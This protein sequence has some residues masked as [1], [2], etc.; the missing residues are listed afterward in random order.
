MKMHKEEYEKLLKRF[1]LELSEVGVTEDM[2]KIVKA[3]LDRSPNAVSS[4]TNE[5]TDQF[6]YRHGGYMIEA[7]QTVNL[8]VKKC[9]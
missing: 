1:A 2:L 8:V 7:T 4:G 9:K 5:T 6:V 3:Q